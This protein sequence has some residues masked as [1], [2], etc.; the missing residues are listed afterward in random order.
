MYSNV[1]SQSI[2]LYNLTLSI[3]ETLRMYPAVKTLN[4]ICKKDFHV[5]GTDFIIKK[6]EMVMIPI[7]AIH[8]DPD[9]YPEPQ[10]FN[11]D[12]FSEENKTNMLLTQYL[13]FGEGPRMCIGKIFRR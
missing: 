6:N 2:Y 8:Y 5:D 10:K 9:L 3:T 7:Q 4:R 1:K 12:R 11:P 13:P